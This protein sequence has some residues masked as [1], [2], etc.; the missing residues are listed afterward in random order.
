VAVEVM[1]PEARP[2]SE[3]PGSSTGWPA[4]RR[5]PRLGADL[6]NGVIVHAIERRTPDGGVVGV[7]RDITAAER[8]L[9]QAKV[10]A[11][12][13]NE[14]KSQFLATMSHEI[15]TP[16]NARAGH[17]R[18][19]ADTVLDSTQRRYV[20]LMRS[21]GQ[22]LLA[23][24]NDILDVSKIE[25]GRMELEIAPFEPAAHACARW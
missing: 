12:A 1:L 23:M 17:E 14:A 13:A 2:K 19:A 8:R 7:Y 6:G 22:A 18:P 5:Q 11:E 20:E 25:A 21:S 4:P 16:L 15:R 24:I 10:A 3:R 9:S